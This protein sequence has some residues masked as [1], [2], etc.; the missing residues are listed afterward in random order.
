MKLLEM[1]VEVVFSYRFSAPH[2]PELSKYPFPFLTKK[3]QVLPNVAAGTS[4]ALSS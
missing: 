4:Q 3:P 1:Y 2:K